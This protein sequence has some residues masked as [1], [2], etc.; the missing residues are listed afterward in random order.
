[1][2]CIESA[3]EFYS[4]TASCLPQKAQSCILDLG[5]GTRLELERYFLLNPSAKVTG[6]DLAPGMLNT[7]KSKFAD[8]EITLILGSYFEV[9]LGINK[10]DAA[11]SVESLHHFTKSEKIPLYTNLQRALKDDGYFAQS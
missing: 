9:D 7:L 11:V 4:Y 3:E 8:K 5:C 10:F 2:T 6:I 1:L